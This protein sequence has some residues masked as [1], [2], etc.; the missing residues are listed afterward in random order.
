MC[1]GIPH[2]LR[3]HLATD[4]ARYLRLGFGHRSFDAG[5][6][7]GGSAG[8]L[9]VPHSRGQL[10]A[11]PRKGGSGRRTEGHKVTTFGRPLVFCV[12]A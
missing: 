4:F 7:K 2:K 9:A 3:T 8:E 6:D 11:K 12:V 1:P 10:Q 5:L